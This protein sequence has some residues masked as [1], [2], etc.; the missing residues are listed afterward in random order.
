M[1]TRLVRI[2]LAIFTILSIIGLLVM[3]FRYLQVPTLL[4]VGRIT[5][6]LELPASGGLY[7]PTPELRSAVCQRSVSNTSTCNPTVNRVPIFATDR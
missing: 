3:G 6:T 1:L 2:Q 7:L 5:V 4:G